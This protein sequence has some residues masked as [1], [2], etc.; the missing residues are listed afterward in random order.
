MTMED[1]LFAGQGDTVDE[2]VADMREGV[3]FFIETSKEKGFPYKI[4]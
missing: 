4:I 3:K 2:A 1:D